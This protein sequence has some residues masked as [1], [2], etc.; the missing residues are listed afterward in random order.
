MNEVEWECRT[1]AGPMLDFLRAC[2]P[3]SSRKMRLFAAS[4]A[5]RFEPAEGVRQEPR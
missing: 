4:A 5:G 3:L 2:N 1:D